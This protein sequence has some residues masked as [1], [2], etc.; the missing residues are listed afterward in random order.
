MAKY[1][2]TRGSHSNSRKFQFVR[3]D[4]V[5][6][7][8]AIVYRVSHFIAHMWSANWLVCLQ[9]DYI[10]HH[11]LS[12]HFR[13]FDRKYVPWA[14]G[15]FDEDVTPNIVSVMITICRWKMRCWNMMEVTQRHQ[16]QQWWVRKREKGSNW[17]PIEIDRW[18]ARVS[19]CYVSL[20]RRW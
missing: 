19:I 14:C 20:R 11:S 12:K 16:R 9:F 5:R 10:N 6:G 13:F 7:G 15:A 2:C 4:I 18:N 8:N 1:P 3:V 17:Q